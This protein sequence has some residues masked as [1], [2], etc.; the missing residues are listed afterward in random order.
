[1]RAA[2]HG[3]CGGAFGRLEAVA[4][5]DLSAAAVLQQ[6]LMGRVHTGDKRRAIQRRCTQDL[7]KGQ[8]AHRGLDHVFQT[9][10]HPR[11]QAGRVDPH[12]FVDLRADQT[13]E[14]R[15]DANARSRQLAVEHAREDDEG[16]GGGKVARCGKGGDG[17]AVPRASLEAKWMTAPW[18]RSILPG[19]A[20]RVRRLTA[21]TRGR[22]SSS[23]RSGSS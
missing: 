10:D 9:H 3:E 22:I 12:A 18:P 11:R 5:G 8:P 23:A 7:A 2:G 14:Q 20:A 19:S 4:A 16:L 21:R 1:M 17:I 15:L 6:I 13:G